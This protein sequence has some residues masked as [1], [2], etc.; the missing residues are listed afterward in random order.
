MRLFRVFLTV[1]LFFGVSLPAT[2]VQATAAQIDEPVVHVVLFYLPT[3]PHCHYVL[4]EVLPPLVQKYGEQLQIMTVNISEPSGQRLFDA[5]L[6]RFPVPDSQRGYVPTLVIGDVIMVGADEVE[7]KL[8]GLIEG[9]IAKG[10]VDWPEVPGLRPDSA[11]LY[12]IATTK[13]AAESNANQIFTY[14]PA[15]GVLA[16]V[17]LVGMIFALGWVVLPLFRHQR[18]LSMTQDARRWLVPLLC[19]LGLGVAGYLT[20]IEM[21]QTTA[22]CGPVGDCNSVQQSEYARLFGVLPVGLLG[23]A[24]YVAILV[25]HA[26][27]NYAPEKWR[28]LASM[29][30]LGMTLFGV[31]FSIYLTYLE[32]FVIQAVCLWCLSSATVSTLLLV[33]GVVTSPSSRP[34]HRSRGP[35]KRELIKP[36]A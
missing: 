34:A 35:R 25:A 31:V 8:P 26:V 30:L 13:D 18:N 4:D 7:A 23:L 24:G 6:G 19:V 12:R 33:F 20:Y 22:V 10:G 36:H 16:L 28:K 27:R 3:C 1:F 14:D 29:G 17:I 21:T 2:T 15:G 11:P 32:I 5:A 9:Y